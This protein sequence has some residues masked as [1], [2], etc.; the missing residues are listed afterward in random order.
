MGCQTTVRR[1]WY[2][3]GCQMTVRRLVQII[4][5][6]TTFRKLGHRMVCL[7]TVNVPRLF[8]GFSLRGKKGPWPYHWFTLC[9]TLLYQIS[10]LKIENN[11]FIGIQRDS[12]RRRTW[13]DKITWSCSWFNERWNHVTNQTNSN[14]DGDDWGRKYLNFHLLTQA[15]LL[16]ASSPYVSFVWLD[17]QIT[18]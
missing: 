8:D 13:K 3:V 15:F 7:R 11:F 9:V 12:S 2:R 4:G 10:F 1:L 16:F 6:R 5:C 17:D 14:H 18:S